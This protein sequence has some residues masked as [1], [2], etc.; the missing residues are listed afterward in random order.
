LLF[1]LNIKNGLLT[2]KNALFKVTRPLLFSA[3]VKAPYAYR[4]ILIKYTKESIFNNDERAAPNLYF[5]AVLVKI[6]RV[7]IIFK[8][9]RLLKSEKKQIKSL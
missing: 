9:K 5:K 6:K 4:E 7:L 3:S 8:R 1:V 2:I